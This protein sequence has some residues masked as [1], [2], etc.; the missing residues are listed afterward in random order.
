MDT[1]QK[2]DV[3]ALLDFD[4]HPCAT[5]YFPLTKKGF[6]RRENLIQLKNLISIA[7]EKLL[8]KDP[9]LN[10]EQM[11]EP[12]QEVYDQLHNPDLL[13]ESIAVFVCE[14]FLR[15][16]T[17]PAH[18]PASAIVDWRFNLKP[19]IPNLT[20]NRKF[21]LLCLDQKDVNLYQCDNYNFKELP[22]E[23]LSASIDELSSIIEFEK[24]IQSYTAP[25][26]KTAGT[27]AQFHGQG[28]TGDKKVYKEEVLL[29]FIHL[30]DKS[31]NKAADATLPLVLAGNK[32]VCD[33]YR[34][35][36]SYNTI[37]GEQI[38]ENISQKKDKQLHKKAAEIAAKWFD[39][40]KNKKLADFPEALHKKRA[41]IDIQ[42]ILPAAR[43]GRISDIFIDTSK[44]IYG[45]YSEEKVDVLRTGEPVEI[46][47]TE[48]LLNLASI[49]SL[50]SQS[51]IYDMPQEQI[52]QQKPVACIFRY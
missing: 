29:Q 25:A 23:N 1:L 21:N 4:K 47:Q 11:F 50:N 6:D 46:P 51:N 32:N 20:S 17:T 5:I 19:F 24:H 31:V 7:K 39:N 41:S 37:I 12:A 14:K 38:S 26:N 9:Q 30:V 27:G 44:N 42:D 8:Q 10:V 33:F 34:R 52:P 3:L 49:F 18:L 13:Q 45:R 2:K 28:A 48:E 40:D 43:V 35:K 22:L 15:N 16:Y 36:T